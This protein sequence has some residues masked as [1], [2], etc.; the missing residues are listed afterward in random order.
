MASLFNKDPEKNAPLDPYARERIEREIDHLSRKRSVRHG[1]K[2][3]PGYRG[4]GFLTLVLIVLLGLFFMDPV[5]HSFRRGDAERAYLYLHHFGSD[6]KA[7]E[8]LATGIFTPN[9]IDLLNQRQGA[10]HDYYP[11]PMEGAAAADS[12]IQYLKGVSNLQRG[13][14]DK[15]STLNKLRYQLFFH[16]GITTPTTWSM[17]DP[18]VGA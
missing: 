13:E 3:P 14:Y 7:Q 4:A 2:K 6:K 8:L 17:L 15:L 10:F 16:F 5:L 18:V 1:E 11:G 12:I 9:E